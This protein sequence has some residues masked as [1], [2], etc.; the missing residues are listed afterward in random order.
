MI[1]KPKVSTYISLSMVLLILIAGLIFILRDFAYKGS[2]GLWFYLIACSIITLVILMLLVKMMAGYRFIT[3][4]RDQI[5]V[6]LPLRGYTKVYSIAQIIAW[7]EEVITANKR[8]FK[9]LTIAFT[10]QQSIS[11]SNHEHEA[12]VDLVDYLSKKAS[13]QKVKN[14]KA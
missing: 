3:A 12:Y 8:Q 5:I 10:D 1:I 11:V 6:K 2:F 4:G 13:K 14:K 7:D 9:Q